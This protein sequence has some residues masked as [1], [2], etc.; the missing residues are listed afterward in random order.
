MITN[1]HQES[2]HQYVAEHPD[3]AE[4]LGERLYD[5]IKT[6]VIPEWEEA[7]RQLTKEDC[8]AYIHN[9][10][11]NRTFDGYVR[12]KS[13]VYDGLAKIFP[14]VRFEESPPELDH[15]GDVD[16]LGYVGEKAFGIQIKPDTAKPNFGNYSISERMKSSFA[17]FTEEYFGKV[18]IVFSLKGEIGNAEIIQEI[19]DEIARLQA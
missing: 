15:S 6:F 16:Y 19:A 14:D 9:L 1:S 12:E 18:F 4:Y 8:I 7:F 11:I 13:V 3:F 17:Q 5:K 10:T 2:L